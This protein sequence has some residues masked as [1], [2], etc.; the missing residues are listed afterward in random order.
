MALTA[1]AMGLQ[2]G[3]LA[4]ILL[5]FAFVLPAG[6]SAPQW[7]MAHHHRVAR[8][9]VRARRRA[10]RGPACAR[11]GAGLRSYNWKGFSLGLLRVLGVFFFAFLVSWS[12]N[13]WSNSS[14]A[15]SSKSLSTPPSPS[16]SCF[17]SPGA[18]VL[19]PPQLPP[20]RLLWLLSTSRSRRRRQAL[21]RCSK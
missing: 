4:K 7:G 12:T 16:G 20:W 21:R 14:L 10:A 17:A 13:S 1:A 5:L 8:T 6:L 11:F 15:R 2:E 19:T 3:A 18:R 9:G